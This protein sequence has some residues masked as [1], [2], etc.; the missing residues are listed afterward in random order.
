MI[1]ELVSIITPL[2]NSEKYIKYAINSVIEQTYKFWELI[3]IDDKSTDKSFEI[4]SEY[5]KYDNRIKV[6]RNENNKGAAFSRNQG[7]KIAKGRYIA[8]LDSDDMW[9]PNKLKSQIEFMKNNNYCFTYT[10]YMEIDE[11]NNQLYVLI[12]GPKKI[13]KNM[14][15]KSNYLGCLTVMF[16]RKYIGELNI[17]NDILKRNDHALWLKVIQKTEC[18][19]LNECHALYRRR[20]KGSLSSTN[21]LDLLSHHYKLYRKSENMNIIKSI[22][23]VLLNLIYGLHRKIKYRIKI[24]KIPVK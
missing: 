8:F 3:I 15:F 14:L 24:D 21:I 2:Y 7:L 5:S 17:R 6:Y 10:N 9:L 19:H 18:Y 11:N 20:K 13:T 16:D 22:Y 1:T 12:T 4:A 23:Y